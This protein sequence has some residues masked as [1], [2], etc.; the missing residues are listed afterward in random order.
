M[1]E[2][3][4]NKQTKTKKPSDSKLIGEPISNEITDV[5]TIATKN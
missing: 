3:S 2:K 1:K 4:K 5:I